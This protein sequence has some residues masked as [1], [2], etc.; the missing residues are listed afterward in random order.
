[1]AMSKLEQAARLM[2]S[3]DYERLHAENRAFSEV[4][5]ND[6]RNSYPTKEGYANEWWRERYA[7][8]VAKTYGGG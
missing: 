5:G 7:P 4:P 1:M 3:Q 2:A 6:F 8:I